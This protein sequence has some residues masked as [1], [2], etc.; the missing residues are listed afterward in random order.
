MLIPPSLLL[1][2]YA[3]VTEV[4][5]GKLFLAAVIPGIVLATAFALMIILLTK[6]MPKFVGV[7]TPEQKRERLA[8]AQDGDLDP[9]TKSG[10]EFFAA[11]PFRMTVRPSGGARLIGGF[12]KLVPIILLMLI[13]LGGIYGGFYSPTEAGAA[14]AF[15]ALVIALVKRRLT[16]KLFWEVMLQTGHISTGRLVPDYGVD[17]LCPDACLERPTGFYHGFCNRFGFWS[18]RIDPVLNGR[19][20]HSRHDPRSDFDRADYRSYDLSSGR[21]GRWRFDLVWYRDHHRRRSGT[22]DPTVGAHGICRARHNGRRQSYSTGSLQGL[23][24]VR[25]DDGPRIIAA[26]QPGMHESRLP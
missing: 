17:V 5:V 19:L 24:P 18:D 10:I 14:G 26:D 3:L 7:E 22:L 11:W 2:V 8:A 23:F 15:A 25:C 13:V 6:I 4:S 16:W 12:I 9:M 1:I 20:A 21:A